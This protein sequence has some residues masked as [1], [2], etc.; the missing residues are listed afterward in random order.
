MA[1]PHRQCEQYF[2][3]KNLNA[4]RTILKSSTLEILLTAVAKSDTLALLSDMLAQR[5]AA[6]SLQ[7]VELDQPLWRVDMGICFHRQSL[8][9]EPMRA[10]LELA[11]VDP[12]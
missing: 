8:E 12:A 6:A 10:L 1:P 3:S 11:G 5:A 7:R 4:P 2:D 9:L